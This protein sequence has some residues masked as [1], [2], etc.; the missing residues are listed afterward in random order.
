MAIFMLV[1]VF[2]NRRNDLEQGMWMLEWILAV[3]FHSK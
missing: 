3:A 1:S 2:W